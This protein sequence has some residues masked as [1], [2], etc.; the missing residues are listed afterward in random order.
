M[1]KNYLEYRNMWNRRLDSTEEFIMD[2]LRKREHC[3]DLIE[4]REILISRLKDNEQY[5]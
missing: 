2:R 3:D 1:N 5:R 4:Y